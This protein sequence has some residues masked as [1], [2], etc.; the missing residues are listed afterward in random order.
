MNPRFA[1]SAQ[2]SKQEALDARTREVKG[3]GGPFLKVPG[4]VSIAAI[5][6]MSTIGRIQLALDETRLVMLNHDERQPRG[7]VHE[8]LFDL[9]NEGTPQAVLARSIL[10]NDGNFQKD[11]AFYVTGEWNDESSSDKSNDQSPSDEP[12]K[13]ENSAPES[14]PDKAKDSDDETPDSSA[15]VAKAP[16]LDQEEHLDDFD[17]LPDELKEKLKSF[18]SLE[19]A[20][21]AT[22][23]QYNVIGI[24]GYRITNARAALNKIAKG[25]A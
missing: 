13:T 22:N 5:A 25:N 9:Q 23:E 7:A 15:L 1:Q 2:I 11:A 19:A 4:L 14:A 21:S 12:E 18:G 8:P 3:D 17:A 10:S 6:V 16:A 20:L 24:S